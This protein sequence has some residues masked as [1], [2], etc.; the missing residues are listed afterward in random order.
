[1]RSVKNFSKY[2]DRMETKAVIAYYANGPIC[3]CYSSAVR[4]L[5][6][7]AVKTELRADINFIKVGTE[8]I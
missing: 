6:S 7:M 1:M 5:S 2:S 3:L 4:R 8:L